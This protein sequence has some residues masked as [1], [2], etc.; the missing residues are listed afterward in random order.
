MHTCCAPCATV[1]PSELAT[2][3]FD[4]QLFFYNPNI[5]PY[6]E[7]KLRLREVERLAEIDSLRLFSDPLY[8]MPEFLRE[9]VQKEFN[10]CQICYNLRQTRT[11]AKAAELGYEWFSTTLLQSPYQDQKALIKAGEE[12]ALRYGVKFLAEDFTP[13][14]GP[15]EARA[16]ELGLYQQAYCGCI[17]SEWE[18]YSPRARKQLARQLSEWDERKQAEALEQPDK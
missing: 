12:A 10:R 5:H 8:R 11:A 2:R 3:G 16:R 17:Y 1:L 15:G 6:R 9:V 4:V 7:F 13:W 14:F 18:R